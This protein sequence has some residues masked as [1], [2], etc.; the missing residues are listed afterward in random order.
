[1]LRGGVTS[2]SISIIDN[3]CT[4]FYRCG[5]ETLGKRSV[6]IG[7]S[8]GNGYFS[9][10]N[11][12][13]IIA[14]M[15]EISPKVYIVVP[16]TPHIHNFTAVGYNWAKSKKK[17]KKDNN[18]TNNRL[19]YAADILKTELNIQNFEIFDW[20]LEVESNSDYKASVE[21]VMNAYRTNSEFQHLVNTLTY[22]YLESRAF[23][24]TINEL[25]ISEGVKYYLKELALFT[26][27]KS[28]FNEHPI[29]AYYKKWGEGLEFIEQ[30]FEGFADQFGM[31]QYKLDSE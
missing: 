20:E 25:V 24:R 28:V 21:V 3:Q 7:M 1:M 12:I 31:I 29:I 17:A 6:V 27:L 16:D 14:G 4:K 9:K 11:M 15:C 10:E 18:Q 30:L 19:R 23:T 22:Q 8:P 26:V 13:D 5:F 2:S